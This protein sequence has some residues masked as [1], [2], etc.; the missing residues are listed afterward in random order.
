MQW[1]QELC[2]CTQCVRVEIIPPFAHSGTRRIGSAYP[3]DSPSP[4]FS[5][6]C[7]Q[8]FEEDVGVSAVVGEF[9]E[10]GEAAHPK[11]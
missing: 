5:V 6:I 10:T 3:T 1:I 8:D 7:A 9:Q 4:V 11:L 2:K